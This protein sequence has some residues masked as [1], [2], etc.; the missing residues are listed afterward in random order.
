MQL[1][2]LENIMLNGPLEQEVASDPD[3]SIK[4]IMWQRE[5]DKPQENSW[6]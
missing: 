5:K 4:H 2:F 6:A 3:A 1:I